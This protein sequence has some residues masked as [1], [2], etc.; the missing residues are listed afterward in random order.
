MYTKKV[1]HRGIPINANDSVLKLSHKHDDKKNINRD[2]S[3]IVFKNVHNGS[4]HAIYYD[5][6]EMGMSDRFPNVVSNG[7]TGTPHHGVLFPGKTEDHVVYTNPEA[8]NV[9]K[10]HSLNNL[11]VTGVKEMKVVEINEH[12][13]EVEAT[14][15][16]VEHDHPAVQFLVNHFEKIG[17]EK[18]LTSARNMQIAK[19]FSINPNTLDLAV[20]GI[21]RIMNAPHDKDVLEISFTPVGAKDG[22]GVLNLETEVHYV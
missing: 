2:I 15:F 6:S 17:D 21:Q 16:D 4:G 9:P 10:K 5:V 22:A 20:S 19:D 3:K 8:V 1:Y 18:K 11:Y 7:I 12:G 14:V 13:K